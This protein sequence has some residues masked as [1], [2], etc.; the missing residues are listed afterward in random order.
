MN[1]RITFLWV[2][3]VIN[4]LVCPA[5][6]SLWQHIEEGFDYWG[7]GDSLCAEESFWLALNEVSD[8]TK[9]EWMYDISFKAYRYSGN[10]EIREQ[11]EALTPTFFIRQCHRFADSVLKIEK[12]DILEAQAYRRKALAFNRSHFTDSALTYFRLAIPIYAR[13][14]DYKRLAF[15]QRPL[16]KL[17]RDRGEYSDGIDSLKAGIQNFRKLVTSDAKNQKYW[18]DIS[19]SYIDIGIAYKA[20]NMPEAAIHHF[21][22]AKKIARNEYHIPKVICYSNSFTSE[23]YLLLED[24]SQAKLFAL[25]AIEGLTEYGDDAYDAGNLAR[26]HGF[27]AQS[28]QVQGNYDSALT[29]FDIALKQFHR[30]HPTGPNRDIAKQYLAKGRCL[31]E[32]QAFEAA[33]ANFQK[34]LY[35][36]MPAHFDTLDNYQLPSDSVINEPENLLFRLLAAKGKALHQWAVASAQDSLLDHSVAAYLLMI[37]A[38]QVFRQRQ[39]LAGQGSR[40]IEAERSHERHEE[41]LAAADL[42]TQQKGPHTYADFW[43]LLETSKAVVLAEHLLRMQVKGKLADQQKPISLVDMQQ[44]LLP[45]QS[46]I[47]YFWGDSIC[48]GIKVNHKGLPEIQRMPI[49]P[50]LITAISTYKQTIHQLSDGAA[51][52]CQKSAAVLYRELIAPF[53]GLQEKLLIIPDGQLYNLPFEAFLLSDSTRLHYLIDDHVIAYLPSATIG[54]YLER[55][56]QHDLIKQPWLGVAPVSFEDI[57]FGKLRND[58]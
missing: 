8:S 7:K 35:R 4:G 26:S 27:L 14:K 52:V 5:Q 32:M 20:W 23:A 34:G 1:H 13:F 40:L 33:I 12:G 11:Q 36:I 10:L 31:A 18:K 30:L 25:R 42:R 53:S 55:K 39:S 41:A 2:C 3:W 46:L 24:P 17:L 19:Y 9:R 58:L 28:L 16:G 37:R 21:D 48:Y 56:P 49:S 50:A 51:D 54:S 38:E 29:H 6:D 15:C 47:S 44:R 45:N 43:E 22:S 57:R